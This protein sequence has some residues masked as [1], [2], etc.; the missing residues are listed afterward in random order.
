M[1]CILNVRGFYRESKVHA[2]SSSADVQHICSPFC[3]SLLRIRTST[4]RPRLSPLSLPKQ[5]PLTCGLLLW[6]RNQAEGRGINRVLLLQ[7]VMMARAASA[8]ANREM[9]LKNH[10]PRP[11]KARYVPARLEWCSGLSWLLQ[12]PPSPP[13]ASG[14][15]AQ[16]SRWIFADCLRSPSSVLLQNR[17]FAP[18]VRAAPSPRHRAEDSGLRSQSNVPEMKAEHVAAL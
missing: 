8:A 12:T 9:R 10:D 7:P 17:P 13:P 11:G 16:S 15:A 2:G 1:S 14:C 6:T 4:P 18:D 3:D 5:H